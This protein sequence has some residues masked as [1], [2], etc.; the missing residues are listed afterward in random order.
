MRCRPNRSTSRANRSGRR[1][2]RATN[3]TTTS[4]SSP[5]NR[6]GRH[7]N[8]YPDRSFSRT[9]RPRHDRHTASG[10]DTAPVLAVEYRPDV[11][12]ECPGDGCLTAR[13]DVEV[14][15]VVHHPDGREQFVQRFPVAHRGDL[16]GVGLG[17]VAVEQRRPHQ[18]TPVTDPRQTAEE[19][20]AEQ[21]DGVLDIE[22]GG[23]GERVRPV[24][25][26]PQVTS[27]LVD[28]QVVQSV[29]VAAEHGAG[30]FLDGCEPFVTPVTDRRCERVE[31]R[32]GVSLQFAVDPGPQKACPGVAPVDSESRRR[33]VR[34]A[35]RERPVGVVG[36]VAKGVGGRDVVEVP[37]RRAH[38]PGECSECFVRESSD[39][40]VGEF[41]AGHR[42]H[43]VEGCGH[44]VVFVDDTEDLGHRNPGVP[45]QGEQPGVGR[46]TTVV[47][48]GGGFQEQ[49]PIGVPVGHDSH[50]V[51]P[52]EPALCRCHRPEVPVG[53][54][55]SEHP[56]DGVPCQLTHR[57]VHRSVRII[58]LVR[59]RPD[60]HSIREPWVL[61]SGDK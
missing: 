14:V 31:P 33:P 29:V 26:R 42:R 51:D 1:S 27:R 19:R 49:H 40:L 53:F 15:E 48:S 59:R 12:S 36:D 17:P 57:V 52:A 43:H 55:E 7:Q 46:N 9:G 5:P 4:S 23:D 50:T 2:T 58:T 8:R 60:S 38:L 39:P 3:S 45:E 44:R 25:H 21:V 6:H 34:S 13:R 24:E 32:G 56:R 47:L 35:T 30:R 41:T 37:K 10:R 22:R 54:D 20:A 11:V 18:I 28:E 16:V 61:V